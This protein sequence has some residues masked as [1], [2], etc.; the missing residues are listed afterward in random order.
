MKVTIHVIYSVDI[1]DDDVEKIEA[2]EMNLDDIDWMYY[3]E[4]AATMELHDIDAG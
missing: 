2:G 1:D 4:K 3:I